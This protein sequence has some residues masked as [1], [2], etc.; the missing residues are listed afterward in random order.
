MNR[1]LLFVALAGL[2]I[3]LL[4]LAACG[5]GKPAATPTPT[6][7][8]ASIA[9]SYL[10]AIASGNYTAAAAMEAPDMLAAAPA[11][12]L[13]QIAQ[14][15]VLQYGEYQ[16]LGEAATAS[17]P[18]YI[19]VTI[20]ATFAYA[21]V[22]LIVTIDANN[23]V[24][25]FHVGSVTPT[26]TPAPAAYVDPDSFTEGNVT[27]GSAP[28]TLPGTLTMPKG[29][30]PF[31]GVVLI[32]GSG[33]NDRD[34]TIGVNKPLRDIAWGLATQGIAVLRYDKRTLV[35]ASEMA[36]LSNITVKEE[37]TDDAIAA[38][39]LLRS[40]PNIDPNR[41][42]LI[43]HSL[44]AYLAPRIAA[45]VP[46]QLAGIAMLEAPSGPLPQLILMQTEYLA[47]LE[48]NLTEQEQQQIDTIKQQVALAESPGLTPSTPA[49]ELPLGI[50]ASYWLDLRTYDPLTTAASLDI[51]MFFSQ[52]GRDYQVP[53]SELGPWET[54]LAGKSDVT[55]KEYPSLDHLL[56]AGTGPSTPAEYAVPSHV[57]GEVV[58]DLAAWVLSH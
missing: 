10:E 47:S 46:G 13:E 33:P 35:Y 3:V 49:S 30:G 34:E 8:P 18:P 15:L 5:A 1:R 39:S 41:V 52:G 22:G 57:A 21:T 2:V 9:L 48:G 44:G 42:F 20:P 31:P 45:E 50:P 56:F 6:P 25:G 36:Q 4:M 11:A 24:A 37:V 53:P 32:T 43:G 12:V 26:V 16:S 28:W 17:V 19:N 14:G 54:A 7:A 58:S 55:F 38:I 27:V 51:P 23:Q 29:T 40:T